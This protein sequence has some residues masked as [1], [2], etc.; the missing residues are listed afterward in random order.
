VPRLGTGEDVAELVLF[1]ASEDAA[2]ITGSEF[3]VDGSLL[4]AYWCSSS[5]RSVGPRGRP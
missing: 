3:L 2:Y 1:L 4:A 5:V